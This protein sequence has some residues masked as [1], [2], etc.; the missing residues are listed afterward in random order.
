VRAV[1]VVRLPS[2]L[3]AADA[4]TVTTLTATAGG[5]GAIVWDLRFNVVSWSAGAQALFGYAPSEVIGKNGFDILALTSSRRDVAELRHAIETRRSGVHIVSR[6]RTKDGR[7]VDCE[8][9]HAPV[10]DAAGVT[11]GFASAVSLTRETDRGLELVTLRDRVTGLPSS[12]LFMDR[13]EHAVGVGPRAHADLALLSIAVDQARDGRDGDDVRTRETFL[14]EVAQ[15]LMDSLRMGDS[16]AR[17]DDDSFLAMLTGVGGRSG[18]IAAAQRLVNCFD[19]PFHIESQRLDRS[20]SI[21]IALFPDDGRDAETMLHCADVAI[22]D[23]R[24]LGGGAFQCYAATA[25]ATEAVSL[26]GDLRFA[27]E[28]GE[29]ELHFQPQ[30][31]LRDGKLCGVEALVRWRHPARGLLFPSDFVTLA[32]QTGTIVPIGLWVLRSACETMRGWNDAGVGIPRIT[33]NVSG[34][35]FGR[36]FVD[37]VAQALCDTDVDPAS[38]ELE[39]T[40]TLT[41]Q[42]S[43]S[44]LQLLDE[45]KSF[46]VRLAIDDFGI[47]YSQLASLSR[48]PVDSLKIDR[49][50]VGDCL[51]NPSNAAIVRGIVTMAAGLDLS[52]VAEGVE[53]T[54]QADFLRSLGCDSAQG[55]LYDTALPLEAVP[56]FASR[57]PAHVSG[58]APMERS[59]APIG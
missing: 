17:R 18:A 21:G 32:E 8:W 50:F 35:Q 10:F 3:R 56:V 28:R 4:G 52:V 11:T 25:G 58:A 19:G 55:Y 38:L 43:E 22:H 30:V 26:E 42:S 48:L 44:F 31:D 29:F 27:L 49:L 47:G 33:V 39:F 40:E 7:S 45:L 9:D 53:S 36:R 13:L 2:P 14:R 24:R 16:L 51:T 1:G 6:V 20:A 34:R 57:A 41:M 46:G 5:V 37:E 12:A 15:R 54:E 23:A 59:T